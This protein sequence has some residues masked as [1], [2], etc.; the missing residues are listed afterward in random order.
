MKRAAL[1]EVGLTQHYDTKVYALS[2]GE[3]QRVA[4]ARLLLQE[5]TLVFADEPTGALDEKNK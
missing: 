1:D 3:Q 4:L 5:P 2:G